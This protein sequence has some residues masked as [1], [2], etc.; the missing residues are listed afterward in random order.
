MNSLAL[1][2]IGSLAHSLPAA[3]DGYRWEPIPELSD[4]FNGAQLDSSK[5]APSHPYWKGREP[6][7]FNEANVS[8][9][10]GR[11]ELRST[12]AV[13]A[14]SDVKDL[15]KDIWVNSACVSSKA[16][17]ASYGYYEARMKA[18]Q[19]SMSSSFWFQG[20]YSEIDVV[21]QFGKPVNRSWRSRYMMMD[22]HYFTGNPKT[23]HNAQARTEMSSGAGEQYHVYGVWW[24]DKDSLVYFLDGREVARTHPAGEFLEPMYMFFDTE[25]FT[26]SGLPSIADLQDDRI[27]TMSVD[28]V[29]SWRLVQE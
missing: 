26:D 21:E 1:L 11:L 15:Q 4:D 13:K 6:S 20:K 25:V 23:D 9:H 8:T 12:A 7:R 10:H 18:S 14:L 29:H 16:P 27:N 19:L 3:P 17:I 5:W 28:W 2:L 24:K 22:S